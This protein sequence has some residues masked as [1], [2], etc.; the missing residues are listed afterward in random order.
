VSDSHEYLRRLLFISFLV[1]MATVLK[2]FLSVTLTD[3]RFT[4]Y[5]I[6][7]MFGGIVLGPLAGLLMGFA[8]DVLYIMI[9]P[10]A[11]APNFMTVSTMLWGFAAGL[12]FFRRFKVTVFRLGVVVVVVSIMA[13]TLNSIQLYWIWGLAPLP[14]VITRFAVMV[15]KW[16]IQ[17]GALYYL[18][19]RV[20]PHIRG[21]HK[22]NA[23]D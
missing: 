8:V 15:I 4:F 5:D 2:S 7:L 10:R 13:F 1:A 22:E 14:N 17:I 19:E 9:D 6:P 11:V 12:V 21:L 20:V 23:E 16:P 18:H 3:F